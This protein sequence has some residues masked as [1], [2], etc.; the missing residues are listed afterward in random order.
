M[1]NYLRLVLWVLGVFAVSAIV[2]CGGGGGSGISINNNNNGNNNG[3]TDNIV[4]GDEN[5]TIIRSEFERNYGLAAI[6]ADAAYE[7]GYFGQGVT[8]A[9]LD[10]G[11]MT[12]H[13]ELQPNI[14]PGY[15]VAR[16]SAPITE[17]IN[18]HWNSI[19]HGTHVGGVIAA[20]ADNSG[21][22]GV[23]PG[24]RLMPLQFGLPVGGSTRRG[25]GG[26]LGGDIVKGIN[27]AVNNNV[28]IVNASF[29]RVHRLVGMYNG[30]QYQA[31]LP[32]LQPFWSSP[33]GKNAETDNIFNAVR[34]ADIVI[35]WAAGN[36]SWNN[37]IADIELCRFIRNGLLGESCGARGTK[38]VSQSDF[39]NGF[40]SEAYR[41]NYVVLGEETDAA[42]VTRSFTI[43]RGFS[44]KEYGALSAL[45]LPTSGPG[46]YGMLPSVYPELENK[47][48]V[49]AATKKD[50]TLASFS[51]GCGGASAWCLSA[52]GDNIATLKDAN[53]VS[54]AHDI[55]KVNGTS[56]A[57]PHVSGALALL[58]GRMPNMPMSV[59]RAVLLTSAT[60]LGERGVDDIYGWGLVN[61][62][63]AI[64]VQGSV[65]I[66]SSR[67]ASANLSEARIK[68]PPLFADAGTRFESV[69]LAVSVTGDS[70]YNTGLD[71]LSHI[72]E[73]PQT[74]L[75]EV[76]RA[77]LD[78]PSS[79]RHEA[80]FIFAAT[81][82]NNDVFRY[83]GAE[84][85]WSS[86]GKW[87]VHHDLCSDCTSPWWSEWDETETSVSGAPIFATDE[88][89]YVLEGAGDDWRP[90]IA[91][92][93]GETPYY[94]Y[95]LRWQ[96]GGN[97]WDLS[98]EGSQIVEEQSFMGADF[99]N[100]GG[101]QTNSRQLRARI[102]GDLGFDMRGYVGY[103]MAR[104]NVNVEDG[105]FLHS[106]SGLRARGWSAGVQGE[107][108]L[109]GDDMWRLSFRQMPSAAGQ[110]KL[111]YSRAACDNGGGDC[112]EE[113]FYGG[114]SGAPSYERRQVIVS[115][116]TVV[117][118]SSRGETLLSAGYA[119]SP[120]D[121]GR[122]SLGAAKELQSGRA[123]LS[124]YLRAE[125]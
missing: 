79:R 77:M 88:K 117:N 62:E 109:L 15:N 89:R 7:G 100:L 92:G 80:E 74:D 90:F 53:V 42:G 25:E 122:L 73:R 114:V 8:V 20:V 59:V 82:T 54:S 91:R 70:Y 19:G 32:D 69:S 87:R 44:G 85:D 27:H 16:E 97:N 45:G 47:W 3:G 37:G 102:A 93:V 26:L 28:P 123:G 18:T 86:L 103:D 17:P 78:S 121:G 111:D 118:L 34:D 57:A 38:T 46:L 65:N 104:A 21:V 22:Q 51:T 1:R 9:V 125:L 116:T 23:A 101:T 48:L 29:G 31:S 106:V 108:A 107:N 33:S 81:D 120:W 98:L 113:S 112:F 99:G 4:G 13:P 83:A 10:T 2:G 24:A 6:R 76:G 61:L 49:V 66:A 110:A 39:I 5:I 30:I 40:V 52:P 60:D 64:S 68:L 119:F 75:S 35:V 50:N 58:K 84:W 67:G 96:N 56:F 11:M 12:T 72:T 115:E 14:V 124:A 43:T 95:G 105:G 94:Q 63:A 41:H 36:E 55:P 71:G